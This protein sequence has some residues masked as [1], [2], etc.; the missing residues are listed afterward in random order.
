M[1]GILNPRGGTERFTVTLPCN[2]FDAC[3]KH[4]FFYLLHV[5]YM[6]CNIFY[7]C[8]IYIKFGEILPGV[9]GRLAPPVFGGGGEAGKC[10]HGSNTKERAG[11]PRRLRR[12]RVRTKDRII[13]RRFAP[14]HPRHG[15]LQGAAAGAGIGENRV[16]LRN[17]ASRGD[18]IDGPWRQAESVAQR[19]LKRRTGVWGVRVGVPNVDR[20]VGNMCTDTLNAV[21]FFAIA[22]K[23]CCNSF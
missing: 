17:R 3:L 20:T 12:S 13:G 21:F 2:T 5:I 16:A 8:V 18:P 23:S 1:L 7:L 11:T 19:R 14:R 9:G 15:V 22:T 4:Y 10:D 6:V